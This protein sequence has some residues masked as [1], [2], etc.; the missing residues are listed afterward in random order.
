MRKSLFSTFRKRFVTGSDTNV[1]LRL[2]INAHLF[3]PDAPQ[4]AFEEFSRLRAKVRSCPERL[5]CQPRIYRLL[6]VLIWN[7]LLL[8]EQTRL[9]PEADLEAV[10]EA[11]RLRIS[12][13]GI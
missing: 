2:M 5:W 1:F 11:L 7:S 8:R 10:L 6:P 13:E 9:G 4:L 3:A 12:F